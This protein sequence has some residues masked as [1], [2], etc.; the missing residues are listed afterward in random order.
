ML[1]FFLS[2]GRNDKQTK[3]QIKTKTNQ[4]TNKTNRTLIPSSPNQHNSTMPFSAP[5]QYPTLH[6]L[7]NPAPTAVLNAQHSNQHLIKFLH[8]SAALPSSQQIG[9]Q[10]FTL[11]ASQSLTT[12]LSM[13]PVSFARHPVAASVKRP[14][15]LL[16]RIRIRTRIKSPRNYDGLRARMIQDFGRAHPKS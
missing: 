3:N 6:L 15:S 11:M 8:P 9:Y 12:N 7:W 5:N 1:I 2:L 13:P 10:A 16:T 14:Q 4:Q